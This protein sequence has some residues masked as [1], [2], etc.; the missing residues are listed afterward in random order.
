[1]HVRLLS[2]F[3]VIILC[4]FAGRGEET[5]F[6]H[7]NAVYREDIKSVRFH[8]QGFE[9]S[10]PVL[11]L[12]E[13]ARLVLKF[14]DLSGEAKRYSYTIL[15]CDPDWNE[16]FLSQS[17]YLE[18]FPDNPI[19]DYARSFNTTFSFVN[20]Y[21]ELPNERVGF[22]ISGNYILL[23]YEGNDRE[24]QVLSRRFHIAEPLVTIEGRV[25]RATT[26]AFRGENHEVD[27]TVIHDQLRIENPR[28]EVRVVIMQNN[29]WDNAIRGLK[30]LFIQQNRLVYDYSRENVFSA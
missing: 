30:P 20:Y 26:D 6:Y 17:Q 29:R 8:R 13:E 4:G 24:K 15:H 22:K 9:L 21:L 2:L 7:G 11:N 25:R 10:N 27:F 18:G 16:S 5:R 28:D 19:D 14:D 3:L 1:M 12:G 23:V